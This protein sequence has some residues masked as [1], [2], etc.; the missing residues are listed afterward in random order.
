MYTKKKDA[1]IFMCICLLCRTCV[2]PYLSEAHSQRPGI[3]GLEQDRT[4]QDREGS[5]G[6]VRNLNFAD[7]GFTD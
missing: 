6:S 1:H 2:S 7:S 3:T 5:G 4:E